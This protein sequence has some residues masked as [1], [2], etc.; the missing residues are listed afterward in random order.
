MTRT[1]GSWI[2]AAALSI[3][4]VA[5]CGSNGGPTANGSTF[6]DGGSAGDGTAGGGTTDDSSTDGPTLGDGNGGGNDGAP[7]DAA[8][9]TSD[10]GCDGC[11]P[12]PPLGAPQCS[13]QTLGAP[14][15]V[16]PLDGVLLPP[17]MNVLEVQWVPPAG[18]A[19]FEV[20]FENAVTD[21]RVETPCNSI[22]SVRGVQN[23]GCGLTLSQAEWTNIAQLNANGDPLQVTVRAAPPGLPCV[24]ASPQTVRIN[25][26]KE[27]L[28]GGIYY[29]QSA[30]YGGIAGTTGGIYYHDFGTFDP[31]PTPFYTSGAQGTCVG[32]HTL[33]KDG[34][35][36]ALMTDDPDA[37]DEYGDVSTHT[38]DVGSRTVIGGKNIGPGFQT[39]THDHLLLIAS[40][41]KTNMNKSFA[42]WNG[43]GTAQLATDPL[44]VNGTQ[45]QG[46][47]PN[48]SADDKTLVF[49]QPAAGTISMAGDH[50]FLGGSLWSAHFD[51]ST[52]A[53]TAFTEL[54][55]AGAGQSFYYPDQSPDGNWVIFNE[56]DGTTPANNDGDC[57]YS[58]QARVKIMHFPPQPGDTPLDLPNLN[59]ADGLSNSW[60]R[61]SPFVQEYKNHHIVWVTFSS[62]RDYGLHLKNTV[63]GYP[64]GSPLTDGSAVSFD[65]YYPPESPSYDQPQPATKQGITF[66]NYA[67]PQIWMAA[68]V[69]DPDRSLDATDRSYPAFWLPFQDVTAHNH[70]AQWVATVQGPPPA[71]DGGTS[72]GDGGTSGGDGGSGTDG[73]SGGT[74]NEVGGPCGSGAGTCCSDVVCCSGS[75]QYS[76]LQ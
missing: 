57:F 71:G 12:F 64:Q 61:W 5:A 24:T 67:A 20:D 70:S 30:T 65:N 2:L 29:W 68:I 58:R 8:P 23:V 14:T 34:M 31:T 15:L 49:V 39:F 1:Y 48:L 76:C 45:I 50:H 10:Y 53:L 38:M 36:M 41:F 27:N 6:G 7:T 46:T 72:G 52:Y 63:N 11:A 42:V 33:S 25:F 62:N 32:C 9:D 17:N 74:C 18:A 37:D 26:A 69:V 4:V 35:R 54:L 75:C 51:T 43:D 16:Y 47:Q 28:A 66:D 21:V 73:S 3:G 56:T 44:V 55:A 60:P 13:P 22:T 40:T 59:V 19:L